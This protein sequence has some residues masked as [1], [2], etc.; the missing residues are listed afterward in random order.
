M[1]N[2]NFDRVVS[3][4]DDY[5]NGKITSI[6]AWWL[7]GF[8]EDDILSP[9]NQKYFNPVYSNRQYFIGKNMAHVWT[10]ED[11]LCKLYSSGA[12]SKSE[13]IISDTSKGKN[14]CQNCLNK[15]GKSNTDFVPWI[16]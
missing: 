10:G 1:D 6:N 2:E 8:G 11:T 16:E 14:I 13:K 7:L 12:L 15:L 5:K 4:L 9:L 3:V